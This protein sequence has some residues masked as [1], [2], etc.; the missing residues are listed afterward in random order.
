MLYLFQGRPTDNTDGNFGESCGFPKR[1]TY[2]ANNGELNPTATE[3]F[4]SSGMFCPTHCVRKFSHQFRLTTGKC[5]NFSRLL[6]MYLCK[7]TI[8]GRA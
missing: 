2:L 1:P 6:D 8:Y 4:K 5:S 7:E 3:G